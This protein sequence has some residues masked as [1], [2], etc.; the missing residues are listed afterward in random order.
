MKTYQG[1]C[2][3]GAVAYTVNIETDFTE[4]MRCNCS[5]CRRKGFL[6]AFA[7]DTAF[8]LLRG[9]DAQTTY[10][11]N[12][13]HIDHSFCTTCGVQAYGYGHDGNGNYMYMINLNCLENFD[14]S[15]IKVNEYD[16]AV[17]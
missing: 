3:C 15:N 16:G 14:L 10:H 2:H 5:H 4:G 6:L 11:F 8:T 17:L 12:K 1:S 13:H 9:G 7:P